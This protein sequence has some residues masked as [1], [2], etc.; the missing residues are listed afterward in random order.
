MTCAADLSSSKFSESFFDSDSFFLGFV[1]PSFPMFAEKKR[2][3][4]K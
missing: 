4:T 2:K 1:G 3:I